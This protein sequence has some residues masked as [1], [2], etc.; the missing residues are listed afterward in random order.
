M[1][2]RGMIVVGALGLAMAVAVPMTGRAHDKDKDNKA[3][4]EAVVQFAHLVS[5]AP[6]A[7]SLAGTLTHFLDPDDVTIGKGGIVTFVV[8]NGGHGIAIY[9]VDKKTT[10]EDIAEDL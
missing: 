5:P 3:P 10:R 6:A 1:K 4:M 8:N 9:P 7:G 2:Y